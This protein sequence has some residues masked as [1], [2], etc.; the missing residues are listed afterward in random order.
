MKKSEVEEGMSKI[1]KEREVFDSARHRMLF[2][3]GF[4]FFRECTVN[5]IDKLLEKVENKESRT[6]QEKIA[7]KSLKEFKEQ[8]LGFGEWT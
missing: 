4:F 1:F 6:E 3:E 7:I 5:Y 8:L 2:K